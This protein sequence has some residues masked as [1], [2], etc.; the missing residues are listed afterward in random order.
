MQTNQTTRTF[1]SSQQQDLF[2]PEQAL[3]ESVMQDHQAVPFT[4]QEIESFVY[5][6]DWTEH[7]DEYN[8]VSP[9]QPCKDSTFMQI[10]LSYLNKAIKDL[11]DKISEAAKAK[12][13]F[14]ASV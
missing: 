7:R 5:I 1:V 9:Y 4:N 14:Y 13:Y 11:Q 3:L 12:E 8:A 2:T 10:Q 6:K